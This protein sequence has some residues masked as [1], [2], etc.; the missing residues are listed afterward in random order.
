MNRYTSHAYPGD[1]PVI[2]PAGVIPLARLRVLS[3]ILF[4]FTVG[5][6]GYYLIEMLF[7]GY[8]HPSMALAGGICLLLLYDLDAT[9]PHTVLPLRA[10]AGAGLITAVELCAGLIVN[11][12]MGLEVWDYSKLPFSF[13]GQ[14]CLFFSLLWF[15]LCIP[16]MALCKAL[17]RR[18]FTR[19]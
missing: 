7:R 9:L 8:S 2:P 16:V 10:L 11:R 6:A 5:G 12:L 1:I 19:S 18:V 15:L 3:E 14:I 13:L 4:L 17:R